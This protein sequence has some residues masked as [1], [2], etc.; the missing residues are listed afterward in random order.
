HADRYQRPAAVSPR[1]S[2]ED[3]CSDVSHG[4]RLLEIA[5]VVCPVRRHPRQVVLGVSQGKEQCDGSSL[6]LGHHAQTRRK[7]TVLGPAAHALYDEIELR[8]LRVSGLNEPQELTWIA[9]L[10]LERSRQAT[11]AQGQFEGLE[12]SALAA[13]HGIADVPEDALAEAF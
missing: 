9:C 2:G 13:C 10:G 7:T 3:R 4:Q 1:S 12:F 5:V 6:P 11:V 8:H